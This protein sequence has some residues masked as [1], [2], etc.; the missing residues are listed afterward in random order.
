[1]PIIL[2]IT[3]ND[4]GHVED[5]IEVG[6]VVYGINEHAA[7]QLKQYEWLGLIKIEITEFSEDPKVRWLVEGF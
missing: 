1:M 6:E 4:G 2:D 5:N 7:N 3:T